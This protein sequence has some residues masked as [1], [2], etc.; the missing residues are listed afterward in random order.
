MCTLASAIGRGLVS[1]D[2]IE[3]R[4]DPIDDFI[5]SDFVYPS[6]AKDIRLFSTVPVVGQLLNRLA[7]PRPVFLQDKCVKC[8]FCARSCPG[9][10]IALAPYPR[11]DLNKCI[12]CFC[13]QELCPQ[14]AVEVRRS[15]IHRLVK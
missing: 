7:M 11:V 2:D 12:R 3:L 15:F 1:P 9:K 8:G 13:C 10:A 14:H 6:A 5:I 4:G